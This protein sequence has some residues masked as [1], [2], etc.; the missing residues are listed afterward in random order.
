MQRRKWGMIG[1]AL[2]ALAV[3]AARPAS[4]DLRVLMHH[5]GDPAPHQISAVVDLGVVALSLLI[6]WS[7]KRFA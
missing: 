3:F 4:A 2:V 6:T 7:T 5:S 1:L